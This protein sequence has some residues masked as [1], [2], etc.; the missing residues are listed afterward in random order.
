M[1]TTTPTAPPVQ[2]RRG[3]RSS[4]SHP[5]VARLTYRALLGRRRALILFALPALLLVI[6]VAVR[7]WPAPTTPPP[8]ACWAASRSPRWCR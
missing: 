2:P 5:T 7:A 4:F 8:A 6:A 3:P 1:S